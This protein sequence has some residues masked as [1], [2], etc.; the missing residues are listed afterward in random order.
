MIRSL[1]G[2]Q[3][4]LLIAVKSI[5][6]LTLII[7]SSNFTDEEIEIMNILELSSLKKALEYVRDTEKVETHSSGPKK[8]LITSPKEFTPTDSYALFI[9]QRFEPKLITQPFANTHVLTLEGQE[10]LDI[11][12]D[13]AYLEGIRQDIA[14]LGYT[15]PSDRQVFRELRRRMDIVDFPAKQPNGSI[16]EFFTQFFEAA[17]ETRLSAP[18]TLNAITAEKVAPADT[19]ETLALAE[20]PQLEVLDPKASLDSVTQNNGSTTQY[21]HN[22]KKKGKN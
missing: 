16:K 5:V 9:A 6:N 19:N 12:S 17:Q 20:E 7:K 2:L 14:S 10:M 3:S 1:R 15:S 13:D 11:L 22:D 4:P 18:A 8:G 21:R